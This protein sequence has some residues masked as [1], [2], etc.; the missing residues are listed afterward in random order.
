VAAF[1]AGS[2]G[3]TFGGTPI[4]MAAVAAT[5]HTI[6]NENVPAK[7]SEASEYLFAELRAHLADLPGVLEIRGAGLLVG[8]LCDAPV[9]D[10]IAELHNRG[11]LVVSAGP[12]VIRLLPNL[13]VTHE[14][15]D[16]AVALIAAV[17]TEQAAAKQI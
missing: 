3:S 4:A 15:I 12:N 16:E 17:L 1:S 10:R 9:A 7:A 13:L 8:I 11:L 6:V 2:H 5:V 14:E